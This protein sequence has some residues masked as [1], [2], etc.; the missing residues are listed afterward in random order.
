[1]DEENIQPELIAEDEPIHENPTSAPAILIFCLQFALSEKGMKALLELHV[2]SIKGVGD[3]LNVMQNASLN[4]HQSCRRCR[5]DIDFGECL[6]EWY[7]DQ[8]AA[9]DL[10]LIKFFSNEREE[11][12]FVLATLGSQLRSILQG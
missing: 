1:M 9:Q 5:A 8:I 10:V 4:I 12:T 6:E 7:V 11:E 3:I 2:S